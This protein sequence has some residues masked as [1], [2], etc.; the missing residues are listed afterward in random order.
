M[1]QIYSKYKSEILKIVAKNGTVICADCGLN[2]HNG[3]CN[4]TQHHAA[5]CCRSSM[6][7]HDELL[8]YALN[9]RVEA[10]KLTMAVGGS[11]IS[12]VNDMDDN[13]FVSVS[14]AEHTKG[15]SKKHLTKLWLITI[16]KLRRWSMWTYDWTIKTLM[17]VCHRSLGPM[18]GF[19]HLGGQRS[20]LYSLLLWFKDCFCL[21]FCLCAAFCQW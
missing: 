16:L 17:P 5:R 13:L 1:S 21:R 6:W 3:N 12:G 9:E 14:H 20:L 7:F 15:V 18:I 11:F 2:P 8:R 10:S 19:I 4:L